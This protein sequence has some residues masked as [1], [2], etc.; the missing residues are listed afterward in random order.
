[1][2]LVGNGADLVQFV[3]LEADLSEKCINDVIM[4]NIIV[5]IHVHAGMFFPC[6]FKYDIVFINLYLLWQSQEAE[7]IINN[8]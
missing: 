6:S 2:F 5:T 3:Q 1:M 4:K 7:S 8:I